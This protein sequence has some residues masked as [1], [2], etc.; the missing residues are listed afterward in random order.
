LRIVDCEG[1]RPPALAMYGNCSRLA[2]SNFWREAVHRKPSW[3]S[4]GS[5]LPRTCSRPRREEPVLPS[6]LTAAAT[7]PTTQTRLI[8]DPTA[9]PPRVNCANRVVSAL[10]PGAR[11]LFV[12]QATAASAGYYTLAG[13][14][15]HHR[16]DPGNQA[17][18]VRTCDPRALCEQGYLDSSVDRPAPRTKPWI[19]RG[20]QLYKLRVRGRFLRRL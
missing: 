3:S 9:A 16:C 19:H 5:R 7:Y 6:G 11:L 14:E 17:K 2:R 10:D 12:L 18:R 20:G 15:R 13:S 1:R 8:P 4:C